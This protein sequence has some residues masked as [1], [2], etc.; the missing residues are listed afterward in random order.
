[1]IPPAD[2]ENSSNIANGHRGLKENHSTLLLLEG[3]V[4]EF[5][6]NDVLDS[7]IGEFKVFLDR[8]SVLNL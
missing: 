2:R 6:A 1:M 5:V 8:Y 7:L 4:N 3:A